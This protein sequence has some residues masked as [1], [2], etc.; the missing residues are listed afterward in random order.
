M[1]KLHTHLELH[2]HTEELCTNT[3]VDRT[4]NRL[5]Q[6]RI[7]PGNHTHFC[8]K[9]TLS[10][11]TGSCFTK[12]KLHWF[13]SVVVLGMHTIIRPSLL[14][15]VAWGWQEQKHAGRYSHCT[16]PSKCYL[17]NGI[18]DFSLLQCTLGLSAGYEHCLYQFTTRSLDLQRSRRSL[19]SAVL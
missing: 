16:W 3:R 1:P 15:F 19:T 6:V 10:T 12:L 11:L 4:Y 17:Y 2:T 9:N 5:S 8:N 14:E 18:Q 7:S 13:P